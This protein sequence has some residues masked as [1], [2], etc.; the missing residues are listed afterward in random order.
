MEAHR[1]GSW[2]SNSTGLNRAGPFTAEFFS[3]WKVP[4]PRVSRPQI[5]PSLLA[6]S[7]FALPLV[8]SQPD[9]KLFSHSQ[10]RIPNCG[11]L[12]KPVKYYF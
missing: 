9:R 6:N 11:F 10:P 12:I 1:L 2:P 8:D 4:Y 5:Q 7:S 3:Q